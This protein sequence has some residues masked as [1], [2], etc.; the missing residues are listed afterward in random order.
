M[1]GIDFD[2]LTLVVSLPLAFVMHSALATIGKSSKNEYGDL[3]YW[4]GMSFIILTIATFFFA[5][6]AIFDEENIIRD[7][8]MQISHYLPVSTILINLVAHFLFHEKT[9]KDNG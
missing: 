6:I 8:V 1:L 5:V 9:V 3:L 7:R 4:I 2:V